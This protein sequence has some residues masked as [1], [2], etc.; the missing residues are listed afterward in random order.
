MHCLFGLIIEGIDM[1]NMFWLGFFA[2]V[3][4]VIALIFFGGTFLILWISSDEI[5]EGE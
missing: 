5:K 1:A 4:A 3:V 2:G